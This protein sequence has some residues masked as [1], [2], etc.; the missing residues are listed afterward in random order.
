MRCRRN[1]WIC[2]STRDGQISFDFATTS[3]FAGTQ[4]S[5]R[6]NSKFANRLKLVA[7]FKTS[8]QN[9]YWTAPGR[10][11]DRRQVCPR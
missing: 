11:I 2:V 9:N 3:H 10:S 5:L 8:A 7:A 1:S 4:K 6:E